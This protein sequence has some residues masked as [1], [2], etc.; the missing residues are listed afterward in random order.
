MVV[1]QIEKKTIDDN[2]NSMDFMTNE[3][4]PL[5]YERSRLDEQWAFER[6]IAMKILH[7]KTIQ[8]IC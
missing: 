3:S 7:S 2:K 4:I 5:N 1:N 8:V 6:K